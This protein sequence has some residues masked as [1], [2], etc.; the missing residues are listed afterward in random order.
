MSIAQLNANSYR[1]IKNG[2]KYDKYFSKTGCKKVFLGEGVT[3]FGLEQMKIL[4]QKKHH[5]TKKIAAVLKQNS[6]HKTILG[7]KNFLH[8]HIQYD[9]DQYKQ[10]LRAPNCSWQ[11][12]KTGVDCKSFSLFAGCILMSLKI[13]FSYRKIK[14]A[15]SPNRWSHVYVVVKDKNRELIIDATVPFNYEVPYVDKPED[16]QV[17]VDLPY[18]GLGAFDSNTQNEAILQFR[19]QLLIL[20]EL[21][22]SVFVTNRIESEVR[23]Y[24]DIGIDPS[25]DFRNDRVI[26]QGVSILYAQGLN[27]A[28]LASLAASLASDAASGEGGKGMDIS[29]L[30]KNVTG[31]F[32]KLFNKES[33]ASVEARTQKA[34]IDPFE[35]HM[36]N[37]L[38]RMNQSNAHLIVT[39]LDKYLNVYIAN[40]TFWMNKMRSRASKAGSQKVIDVFRVLLQNLRQQFNALGYNQSSGEFSFNNFKNNKPMRYNISY[41]AYNRAVKPLPKNNNS[42]I[43]TENRNQSSSSNKNSGFQNLVNTVFSLNPNGQNNTD[44][45]SNNGVITQNAQG[46]AFSGQKQDGFDTDKKGMSTTTKVVIGVGVLAALAIG[47]KQFD[48]I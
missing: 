8:D 36:K 2:N 29:G 11:S 27:A 37:E 9:A 39:E 23:K 16:M 12:R 5:Q 20:N 30:M 19:D 32:S 38:S 4:T 10:Q 47:A 15:S 44:Q 21:G 35:R 28:F 46:D 42:N 40:E 18:Y 1:I 45:W 13:P 48:I 14:Q 43:F 25:I 3:S 7:I 34:I 33:V 22:I 24:T 41:Y 26:V 31:V 6:L 17:E